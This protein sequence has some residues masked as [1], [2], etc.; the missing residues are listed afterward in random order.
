MA[1]LNSDG[2][3]DSSFENDGKQTIDFG[4][5]GDYLHSVAVDGQSRIVVAG[6]S[7]QSGTSSDFA[8]ARLNSDGSLD[9]SFGFATR[10]TQSQSL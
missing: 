8:M 10:S 5:S 9:S 2:S 3:L 6:Y 1:R 7:S 4:A